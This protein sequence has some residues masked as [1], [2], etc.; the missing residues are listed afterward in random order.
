MVL[1]ARE[2][3]L[4]L[5]APPVRLGLWAPA[6]FQ[7]PTER[8]GRKAP[9]APRVTKVPAVLRVVLD[10]WVHAVCPAPEG[11]SAAQALPALQVPSGPRVSQ[12]PKAT[13]A[14]KETSAPLV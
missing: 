3:F 11:F 14:T 10:P 12:V 13:K 7:E 8:K 6:D 4:E 5:L 9:V 2:G 1:R